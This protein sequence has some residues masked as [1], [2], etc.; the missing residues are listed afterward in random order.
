MDKSIKHPLWLALG[1]LFFGAS[2][3]FPVVMAALVAEWNGCALDEG[4]IHPCVILGIDFGEALY[5]MAVMFWFM[6]FTLPIGAIALC[7]AIVWLIAV[8]IKRHN[9]N[10]ASE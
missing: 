6:F 1:S 5:S 8:L 7:G 2:P 4:N 9:Y 10:P 3:L